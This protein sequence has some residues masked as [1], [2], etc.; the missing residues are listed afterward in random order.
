M[1]LPHHLYRK[2]ADDSMIGL[3]IFQADNNE[4]VYLNT[5]ARTIF[6][7][8]DADVSALKL[9]QLYT[10]NVK[11]PF[12]DFTV[13]LLENEGLIEDVM[14]RKSNGATFIATLEVKRMHEKNDDYVMIMLQD[15]TFQKKLQREVHI[16]QHE[17][18]KTYSEILDQNSALKSLDKAKNKFI[19][20]ITHELRTPLSAI[21]ATAEFLNLKFYEN[22]KQLEEYIGTIVTEGHH[23]L[24]IVN[25]I[26][27]FSKIQ[28]GKMDFFL[29]K[30]DPSTFVQT[31]IGSL[32][33]MAESNNV[34]LILE[35]P[36]GD[37]NCYFDPLRFNQVINNV[38]SNAIKFNKKN[39][40]VHIRVLDQ[41]EMVQVVV[42]DEGAGIPKKFTNKVFDEFETLENIKSHHKG[43]GLGMPISKKL[44][45]GMG[46]TIH[47]TS[48]EGVGTT[49]FISIPKGK[50]LNADLYKKRPE[51]SSDL[52]A[53]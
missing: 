1:P 43:T 22:E 21:I 49:F 29:E 10:N 48:E 28:T 45:E 25:D 34:Q 23:L 42:A 50:I 26:L 32:Q 33:K 30:L 15:V 36:Q 31:Q 7:F 38:M 12:R 40:H 3:A 53:S 18:K 4:G 6:E 39:G 14:L 27:D 24:A 13:D 35:A 52:I 37:T 51:H 47:F 44:I 16:K 11:S 9:N 2:I 5:M 46:G 8:F 19:A 41:N 17:L 20:L